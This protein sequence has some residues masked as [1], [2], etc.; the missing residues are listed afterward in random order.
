MSTKLNHPG[1]SVIEGEGIPCPRCG[2]QTIRYGRT[3]QNLDDLRDHALNNRQQPSDVRL[4][5]DFCENAA[6]KTKGVTDQKAL[7]RYVRSEDEWVLVATLP[8]A[9]EPPKFAG[10]APDDA[11]PW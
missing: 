4:Y 7:I 2:Q 10:A 3:P 11:P 8:S 6:C 5:G 1:H 9:P